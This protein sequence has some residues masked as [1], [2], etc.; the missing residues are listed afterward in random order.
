MKS[1]SI[2]SNVTVTSHEGSKVKTPLGVACL[3]PSVGA[4][5][6]RGSPLLY[7]YS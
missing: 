6:L 3:P 5:C 2:E 1:P 4:Q 7:R